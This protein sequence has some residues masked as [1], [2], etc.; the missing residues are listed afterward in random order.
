M[1]PDPNKAVLSVVDYITLVHL[2]CT[3]EERKNAQEVRFSVDVYLDEK[4]LAERSDSLTD[5]ICYTQICEKI[6]EL[7]EGK[8]FNLV[9]S[10]ARQT[11][12]FIKDQLNLPLLRVWV[13]KVSPPVNGLHGGVKYACSSWV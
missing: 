2:G 13:H 10:L 12:D 7:V 1:Q 6:Q 9:E 11:I 5:T 4:L 8:E 3:E